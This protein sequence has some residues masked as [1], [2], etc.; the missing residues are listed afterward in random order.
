MGECGEKNRAMLSTADKSGEGLRLSDGGGMSDAA[1]SGFWLYDTF[2]FTDF[3]VDLGAG[4]LQER[5]PMS[6]V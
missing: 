5:L 6:D 2:L 4:H 3:L 1:M